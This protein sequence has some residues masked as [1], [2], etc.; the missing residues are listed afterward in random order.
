[1]LVGAKSVM[2][3]A[4]NVK[5]GLVTLHGYATLE[6]ILFQSKI[7][8]YWSD[9]LLLDH[10]SSYLLQSLTNTYI[11]YSMVTTVKFNSA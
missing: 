5:R 7:E 8:L 6:K 11:K 9:T 1:M 2:V 10:L 3:S 4:L